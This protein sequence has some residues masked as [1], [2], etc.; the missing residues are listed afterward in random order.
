MSGIYQNEATASKKDWERDPVEHPDAIRKLA[1]SKYGLG[2][3]EKL[4][5]H[6]LDKML[7]D[8]EKAGNSSRIKQI[9]RAKTFV[10]QAR[11]HKH[12]KHHKKNHEAIASVL[13]SFGVPHIVVAGTL[14][15]DDFLAR[16]DKFETH[17]PVTITY[18]HNDTPAPNMGSR[19]GQDIEPT[20]FYFTEREGDH[21]LT[22]GLSSGV[23]EIKN[24][25][26]MH[27]G[28][29]YGNSD[30]WKNVLTRVFGL[31]G[32]KLSKELMRQGYTHIITIDETRGVSYPSEMVRLAY[33]KLK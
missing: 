13:S 10:R 5:I 31:T 29:G 30:C 16:T 11:H 14:G 27:W 24:P 18:L 19:F 20:G 2:E 28:S 23:E 15:L 12:K 21:P 22:D 4:T 9:G 26:V 25:L 17:K 32:A 8:A 1:E 33:R 7:V 3:H 6:L